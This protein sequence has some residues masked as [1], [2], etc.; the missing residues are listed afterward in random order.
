MTGYD[1][2]VHMGQQMEAFLYFFSQGDIP[3]IYRCRDNIIDLYVAG[4]DVELKKNIDSW[5]EEKEKE[6]IKLFK[7]ATEQL[8]SKASSALETMSS[9]EDGESLFIDMDEI[10][11]DI[12]DSLNMLE[13][14]YL[15]SVRKALLDKN[16]GLTD[17]DEGTE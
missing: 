16:Q 2:L 15:D 6:K 5:D 10:K 11:Q 14:D 1:V 9:V 3:G 7:K 8:I 4:G 12:A 17:E 13:K